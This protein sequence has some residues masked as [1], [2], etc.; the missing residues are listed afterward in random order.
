MLVI[1]YGN[2]HENWK[3]AL[4]HSSTIWDDLPYVE[5]VILVDDLNFP[6]KQVSSK[7]EKTVLIPLKE[8]NIL[9]HP[10]GYLTLVPSKEIIQIASYKDKFYDFLTK[11]GFKENFPQPLDDV[12]FTAPFILKRLHGEGGFGI[13]LV[14]D[15][16][17]YKEVLTQP[18]LKNEPYV[19]EEYIEGDDEYIFYAVCKSGEILWSASLVGKPPV[20][21][22]VQKG[23]FTNAAEV[24]IP[25]EIYNV[26]KDIFK[27]LNYE[28][29]ANFN[30]KL[31]N[32]KPVI[33]E[34]NPRMG[35]TLMLPQFNHLL[36]G[37]VKAIT[38]NAYL[39][40]SEIK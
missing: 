36:S 6:L 5:T 28:G 3:T 17:R 19:L 32:N 23:S 2:S 18:S 12:D 40:E 38:L 14:W 31:K 25:L 9:S 33:F 1:P 15:E 21:S 20:D 26:F 4:S 16:K 27:A 7:Y 11:H 30:Y 10:Q 39:K 29:P 22:R 13:F 8:S 37:C 24:E 34:M 35:G